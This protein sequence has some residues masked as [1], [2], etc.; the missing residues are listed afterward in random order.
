MNEFILNMYVV[1]VMSGRFAIDFVPA[2]YKEKVREL[3]GAEE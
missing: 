2:M 1:A 3:I